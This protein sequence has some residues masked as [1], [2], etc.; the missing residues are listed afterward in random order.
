MKIH[1]FK[2]TSDDFHGDYKIA[3]KTNVDPNSMEACLDGNHH[4]EAYVS[5]ALSLLKTGEYRVNV[6]G[7]D[8]FGLERDYP[9]TELEA[10]R[11]MY[12]LLC[13]KEDILIADLLELGFTYF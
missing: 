2:F 10:A 3:Y 13:F 5:V 8:D 7:N 4:H 1:C 12:S 6:W 11:A 9:N